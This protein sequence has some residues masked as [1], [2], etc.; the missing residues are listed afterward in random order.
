MSTV[1]ELNVVQ[2]ATAT[3]EEI[4]SSETTSPEVVRQ[5]HALKQKLKDK[6]VILGHHYQRDDVV[7][8]ADRTG[9][10]FELARFAAELRDREYIIFCG[11]H[12]MAETADVLS[13]DFQKVILPDLK[14]GCSM[15]DMARAEQVLDVWDEL[16]AHTDT[17]KVCP[18]TYMNSTAAIKAF[19]GEH[20][21]TVSTSSNNKAIFEW[22]FAN[23][24]EKI[25][26]F[27]DQHLGRNTAYFQ[28]GI[29]LDEILLWDQ[30]QPNGGLTPEQI[31]KAK[32][33]LW[34]G[35]CSVHQHFQP[36]HPGIMRALYPG[37]QVMV[38]PECKYEVVA[39]ADKVGSTAYII[40]T[41][42]NAPAGSKWAIGT[43]HHLVNRL[44]Q[45]HPDQFITTLAPFACECA[46]MYRISPESLLDILQNLDKG[47][48]KN[49]ITVED[50]VKHWAKIALERMLEITRTAAK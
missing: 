21:G 42:E 25:F 29:P 41:V 19:C 9:D 32:I 50:D 38:H 16:A 1:L 46:T 43:E 34:R 8:F 14:A 33:F 11:V 6:V 13:A 10:S 4:L 5:V 28:L 20:G 27:P 48:I 37:L 15:A 49:Q 26:F 18:I 40:K 44:K 45:Q 2:E 30:T 3:P 12:F 22:A 17:S 7:Q 36:S 24:F 47:I 35:H 39:Q 23:G 31:K